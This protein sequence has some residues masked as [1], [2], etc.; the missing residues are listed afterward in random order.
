MP[1]KIVTEDPTQPGVL[2]VNGPTLTSSGTIPLSNLDT[3]GAVNGDVLVLVGGVFTPGPAG[4]G[5]ADTASNLGTGVGVFASKVGADFQFKSL[6]AGSNIAFIASGT[7]IQINAASSGAGQITILNDTKPQN[8]DGGTF[9]SGSF[10]TRDI[11]TEVA[12]PN[13]NATIA[14]NQITLQ[15]GTYRFEI[16]CPAFGVAQHQARLQNITDAVTVQFGSSALSAVASNIPDRSIIVGRVTIAVPKVF[17][18]QHQCLQT[19]VTN[20]FGTKANFGPEIYTIAIFV[21]E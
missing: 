3:T 14:A 20:G 15:P 2:K 12:D 1:D 8:T 5:S 9:A 10:L 4:P 6:V 21:K 17:E 13:N 18:I 7:E 11:N 16:T 19:Q